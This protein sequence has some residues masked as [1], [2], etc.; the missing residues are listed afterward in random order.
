MT[1]VAGKYGDWIKEGFDLYKN[2]LA[3]LILSSLIAFLLTGITLGILGGPMFAGLIKIV[4]R[5][6]DNEQPV[7]TAGDVFQGFQ[8]FLPSFLF[9][10][11]WGAIIIVGSLVLSFIP[12]LGQLLVIC[13]SF[14]ASAFLMFGLFLIVDKQMDFWP[15]SMASIEK[16]KPTFFPYLGL[17][18]IAG[19]IGEIGAVAC[20]IGVF[21]TMPIYFTIIATAYRDVFADGQAPPAPPMQ[22]IEPPEAP[23][24]DSP[25]PPPA[26]AGSAPGSKPS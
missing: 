13:L 8:Y 6:R 23:A 20:G 18:V 19:I 3:V 5:I 21:A 22:E 1:D 12:C 15:A 9:T 2:N 26:N 25:E 11:V 24:P 14:A 17:A 4:L 10:I 7:P 16:V